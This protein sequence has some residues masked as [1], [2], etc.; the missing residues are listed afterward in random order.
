MLVINP[1]ETFRQ[2]M[3]LVESGFVFGALTGNNL[4]ARPVVAV[5][6]TARLQRYEKKIR[7]KFGPVR[8]VRLTR[9]EARIKLPSVV[10][11]A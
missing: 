8:A 4:V 2:S 9:G 6:A 10:R 3:I 5:V 1:K 11:G 7:K